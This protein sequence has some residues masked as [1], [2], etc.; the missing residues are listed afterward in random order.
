MFFASFSRNIILYLTETIQGLDRYG[1]SPS[2]AGNKWCRL[3]YYYLPRGSC[4]CM[5]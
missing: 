3:F 1:V 4:L 5:L 2:N